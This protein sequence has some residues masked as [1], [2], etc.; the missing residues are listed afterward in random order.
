MGSWIA[1]ALWR[2]LVL[3]VNT[4]KEGGQLGK[5]H[6]TPHVTRDS[7]ELLQHTHGVR[8]GAVQLVDECNTWHV[9]AAREHA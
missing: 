3:R 9:V 5:H 7:L 8:P 6:T 4:D 1:A 2:S